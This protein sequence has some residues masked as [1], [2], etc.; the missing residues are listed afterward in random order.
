[1][2]KTIKEHGDKLQGPDRKRLDDA[3]EAAKEALKSDDHDAIVRTQE[4]LKQASF[5]LSEVLY[6][7]QAADQAGGGEAPGAADA[8]AGK[9]KGDD[10]VVDAE[11]EVN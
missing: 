4:E 8:G 7:S 3:L 11:F 6:A 10:D 9:A 2:E 5:K 1:M